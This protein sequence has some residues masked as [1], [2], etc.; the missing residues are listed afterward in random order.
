MLDFIETEIAYWVQALQLEPENDHAI[1]MLYYWRGLWYQLNAKQAK[2][3]PQGCSEA[4][5][6]MAPKLPDLLSGLTDFIK[7][8][9]QLPVLLNQRRRQKELIKRTKVVPSEEVKTAEKSQK[10]TG[11]L[12]KSTRFFQT[13]NPTNANS[14]GF[15]DNDTQ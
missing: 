14:T 11:S 12:A 5:T 10:K 7:M 15:L 9:N 2:N 4:V 3:I 1:D 8:R 13:Q 6:Q